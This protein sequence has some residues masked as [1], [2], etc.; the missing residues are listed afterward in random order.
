MEK[1][2]PNKCICGGK[3][4]KPT[5]NYIT[6]GPA[7]KNLMICEKCEILYGERR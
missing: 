6:V 5:K 4:A 1:H 3:L 2:D 7:L